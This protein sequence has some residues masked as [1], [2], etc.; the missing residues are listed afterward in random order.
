[1]NNQCGSSVNWS[2]KFVRVVVHVDVPADHSGK[3]H[4]SIFMD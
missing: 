1:M 4:I 3:F 2:L